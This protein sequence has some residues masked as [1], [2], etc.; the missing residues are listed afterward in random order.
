MGPKTQIPK[1]CDY[2][3]IWLR[4]CIYNLWTLR[5]GY[6]SRLRSSILLFFLFIEFIGVTLVNKIIQ[7]SDTQFY[8]TSSVH[9]IVCSPPQ[10]KSPSITIYLLYTLFYLHLHLL[11]WQSPHCCSSVLFLSLFFLVPPFPHPALCPL[12][13]SACFLSMNLSLFCLLVK[14]I[15]KYLI[16]GSEGN[17]MHIEKEKTMWSQRHIMEWWGHK[18]RKVASHQNLKEARNE[19]ICRASRNSLTL[20]APLF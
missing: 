17:S 9:G 3:L 2:Y 4:L 13:L 14:F 6:Y 19:F 10:V 12:Q 5:W 7:V 16:K 8:N 11:S 18:P 20:P 1:T 15:L